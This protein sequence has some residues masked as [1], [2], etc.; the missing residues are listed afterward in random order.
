LGEY[1][2]TVVTKGFD[3]GD[4]VAADTGNKMMNI[5][6]GG[7]TFGNMVTADTSVPATAVRQPIAM[8][9]GDTSIDV[10]VNGGPSNEDTGRAVSAGV[11][12][13]LSDA[14]KRAA[15]RALIRG[16]AEDWDEQ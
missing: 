4:K 8:Q 6:K 15:A 7:S 1:L 9:R 5:W 13:A 10:T 16:P 11:K 12:G 2:A 14:D 3:A